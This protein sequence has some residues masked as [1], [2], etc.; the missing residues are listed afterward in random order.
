MG[1]A[2]ELISRILKSYYFQSLFKQIL[3]MDNLL[4]EL[5][6]TVHLE[7]RLKDKKVAVFLRL[8]TFHLHF[9]M[10]GK[11]DMHSTSVL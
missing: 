8:C 6:H 1:I 3:N 7:L 2:N 5:I 4:Y 10:C 9:E 11:L